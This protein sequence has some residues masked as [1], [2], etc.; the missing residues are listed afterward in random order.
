MRSWATEELKY[1]ALPD[2]QLNQRLI[3]IVENLS[4]QP[5]ASFHEPSPRNRSTWFS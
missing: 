5:H 1:V 2:K 3:R 4:Q